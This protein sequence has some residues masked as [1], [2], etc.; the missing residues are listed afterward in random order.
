[1]RGKR[2]QHQGPG[3]SAGSTAHA[4]SQRRVHRM[5]CKSSCCCQLCRVNNNKP[6]SSAQALEPPASSLCV[7]LALILGTQD[8]SVE[9]LEVGGGDG[10]GA[11]APAAVRAARPSVST[12]LILSGIL[13]CPRPR[14]SQHAPPARPL[15][16]VPP[17]ALSASPTERPPDVPPAQTG[18]LPASLA[19]GRLAVLGAAVG[20][21]L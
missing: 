5:H 8:D 7:R 13:Q 6:L 11:A 17:D 15:Q 16:P 3:S 19:G 10:V 20:V 21:H 18:N 14:A 2:W 4:C 9:D 12:Q 1:M